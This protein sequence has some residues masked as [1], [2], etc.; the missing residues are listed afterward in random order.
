[1]FSLSRPTNEQIGKFLESARALPLS[2]SE[3]G[4]TRESRSADYLIDHNRVRLGAGANTFERAGAA[5]KSWK[6]FDLGW[7]EPFPE[8][9]PIAVDSTVAVLV[10]HSALWSLNACRIVYL[11]D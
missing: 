2:Y 7:V 3:V 1:M 4:M 6:H 5:L 10:N 11:V 9:A 8:A